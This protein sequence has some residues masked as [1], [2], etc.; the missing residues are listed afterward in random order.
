[1]NKKYIFLDLDGTIIDHNSNGIPKSTIE[2]IKK[3]Q[4]NGHEII[5]STG[6]PPALF[7]DIDKKL[8][9]DS[10]IASNGRIVVYKKEIILNQP[11][12]KEVVKSLVRFALDNKIDL[13]FESFTDY[14]LNSHFTNLPIKFSDVYHLDYP[15][16]YENYHLENDIYQMILFYTESD[17]RKFEIL[18]PTL[19]FHYSNQYGLDINEKGGMK[20]IGVKAIVDFANINIEDTIAVGDGFN[21]ISMIEHA[22]LGVAMGNA[23]KDLKG[24]ADMI[25]DSV[26]N[27][28]IYKL[29][30]QLKMI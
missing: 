7:Y 5:I 26:D 1:M 23:Y 2:T 30:K 9:I 22:Y 29:F 24:A 3:L 19:S 6:R 8:N 12:D 11:I 13:A 15:E 4:E 27:D 14:V 16:V 20:D 10:Y 18:F 25:T 17:Y 21:D 28:G